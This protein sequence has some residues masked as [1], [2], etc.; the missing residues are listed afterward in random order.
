MSQD[1]IIYLN[2][3]NGLR[4]IASISV[5]ISHTLSPTFGDFGIQSNFHLPLGEFG[6]TLFFVISGFLIT[7]LLLNEQGISNKINIKKF[8]FRRILR[9][10]PIYYLFILL[11]YFLS[12]YIFK[13]ELKEFAST[14]LIWYVLFAANIPFVLSSG[15]PII[16]HFWSIGVEEQFYLIWP[17]VV[18]YFSKNLVN[19]IVF[20]TILFIVIK[21]LIWAYIGKDSFMYR[22]ISVTR[23]HCMMLGAIGSVL[24]YKKNVLFVDFVCNVWVQCIAWLLFI[25][26]GVGFH[27]SAVIAHELF[28]IISLVIVIGQVEP[29]RKIL[30]L[31][32]TFF[33]FL[34]KISYGIYVYHP[35]VVFILSKYV[36][37]LDINRQ[38]EVVLIFSA[39]IGVT[40]LISH[41]SYEYY[42]KCFIRLKTRLAI[43]KST[44]EPQRC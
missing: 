11:I 19:R 2:G 24:F 12:I 16:T 35:L 38:L 26:I 34:G 41:F 17:L 21:L 4:A 29:G 43:V 3:L 18:K 7:F 6:V 31:E 15:I 25:I 30:C 32:N 20:L 39:V 28:A 22:F 5:V 13:A 23:I 36:R 42:E 10:W 1:K 14:N 27:V 37:Y 40:I 9:I 33:N 44:N 8:Y